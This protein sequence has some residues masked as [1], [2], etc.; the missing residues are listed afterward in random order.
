M[1]TSIPTTYEPTGYGMEWK[2]NRTDCGVVRY[3]AIAAAAATAERL[4]VEVPKCNIS[5]F[6][7]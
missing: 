3:D 5:R 2:K 1:F 7:L 6:S 4:D